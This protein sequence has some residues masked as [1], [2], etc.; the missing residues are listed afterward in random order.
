MVKRHEG[1]ICHYDSETSGQRDGVFTGTTAD[2]RTACL[3]RYGTKVWT[4]RQQIKYK[5]PW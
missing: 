2:G 4:A 1:N 3:G 5:L